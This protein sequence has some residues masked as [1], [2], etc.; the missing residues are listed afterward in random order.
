MASDRVQG[1]A[2]SY[3]LFG[4]IPD[5]AKEQLGV[6]IAI[7]ARDVL[8]LQRARAPKD[9][10]ALA[11]ELVIQL[12]VDRLRARVGLI[13]RQSKPKFYGRVIEF[14]R[15]AQTVLVQRRRRVNGRL[16]TAR[17]RKR[18][19]DI[20]ATYPLHVKPR[21]PRPFVIVSDPELDRINTQRLAD[22][23]STV[24]DK[25]EAAA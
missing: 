17:G 4:A 12:Q 2:E 8:A 19:E 10:G 24:I 1:L 9:T 3:A 22:F 20:A 21:E 16:R 18:S 14:G 6:E 11:G 15:K 25:A 7:I 5:A 23:W 13:G